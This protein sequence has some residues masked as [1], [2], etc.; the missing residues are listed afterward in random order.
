M[1]DHRNCPE[2]GSADTERVSQTRTADTIEEIRICNDCPT[3]YTVEFGNPMIT[4]V[5][6]VD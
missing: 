3:N 2:C 4:E 1:T 6:R 5:V